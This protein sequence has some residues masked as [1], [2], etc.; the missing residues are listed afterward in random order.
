LTGV[1]GTALNGSLSGKRATGGPVVAG[2]S[3]LVGENEPEIFTPTV[4]GRILN[5]EQI[6]KQSG[7]SVSSV[8]NFY[9]DITL[10]TKD[11]V[12]AFAKRFS[13]DKEMGSLGVGV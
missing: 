9:G 3:Y 12:D 5:Q 4:S 1:P 7:N 13:F 2:R 11:S 6:S 8:V 10:T